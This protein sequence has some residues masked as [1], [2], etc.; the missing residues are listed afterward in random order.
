VL[1]A[2]IERVEPR[3]NFGHNIKAV[4]EQADKN[5]CRCDAV[6][7]RRVDALKSAC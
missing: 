3:C 2:R 5:G 7:Y 1:L 6:L 4:H